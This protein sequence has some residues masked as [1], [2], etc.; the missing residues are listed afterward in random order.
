V[1][2]PADHFTGPLLVNEHRHVGQRNLT[3][4]A[5]AQSTLKLITTLAGLVPKGFTL[6]LTQGGPAAVPLLQGLG[7]GA[8]PIGTGKRHARI[9]A[10]A[11]IDI[12]GG[13]DIG[14]CVHLLT[15]FE[16]NGRTVVA[17]SA[18][19]QKYAARAAVGGRSAK[20]DKGALVHPF[21]EPG[22]TRRLLERLGPD[23]WRELGEVTDKPLA[24]VLGGSIARMLDI[25]GLRAGEVAKALGGP[26]GAQHLLRLTLTSPEGKLIGGYS[27]VLRASSKPR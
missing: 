12:R 19:L 20:D 9:L 1:S 17:R 13:V 22:G 24:K 4:L 5:P 15:A 18:A 21:A 26:Y 23:L 7:G 6:E 16:A 8:L 27:L 2:C 11:L 3:I 14:A 10:P 25:K